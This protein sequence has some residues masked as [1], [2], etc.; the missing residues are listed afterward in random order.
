MRLV[1]AVQVEAA[2]FPGKRSVD[3]AEP[4]DFGRFDEIERGRVAMQA[5]AQKILGQRARLFGGR[6]GRAAASSGNWCSKPA[7]SPAGV[8]STLYSSF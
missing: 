2:F 4:L 1:G 5:R 6:G 7:N 8:I 3:T